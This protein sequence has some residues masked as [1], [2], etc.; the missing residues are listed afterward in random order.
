MS[1]KKKKKISKNKS[2]QK[3]KD[4]HFRGRYSWPNIGKWDYFLENT[5]WKMTHFPKN[6]NVETNR[7]KY[8]CQ[9]N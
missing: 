3:T 1:S 6:V 2:Y 5:F 8:Y 4:S 9:K 7:T